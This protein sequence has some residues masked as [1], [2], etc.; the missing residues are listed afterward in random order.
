MSLLIVSQSVK[1]LV[2]MTCI[3]LKPDIVFCL[4]A[5]FGRSFQRW[6]DG[7]YPMRH[8]SVGQKSSPSMGGGCGNGGKAV[9][10]THRTCRQARRWGLGPW[11]CHGAATSNHRTAKKNMSQTLK[12]VDIENYRH[13]VRIVRSDFTRQNFYGP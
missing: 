11:S 7:G 12:H 13:C 6:L 10:R 2:S 5:A 8:R 1:M 3:V 4:L 9:R